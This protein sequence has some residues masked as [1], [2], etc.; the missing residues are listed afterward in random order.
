[1]ISDKTR[2][3]LISINQKKFL[4]VFLI[5]WGLLYFV[6]PKWYIPVSRESNFLILILHLLYFSF[7]SFYL[8]NLLK[9]LHISNNYKLA[10]FKNKLDFKKEY[11]YALILVGVVLIN[12]WFIFLVPANYYLS[13]ESYQR[14]LA[15]SLIIKADLILGKFGLIGSLSILRILIISGI[16]IT[17][18]LFKKKI[19]FNY[20]IDWFYSY[21]GILVFGFV[22]LISSTFVIV[23]MVPATIDL[24]VFPQ[25]GRM[26]YIVGY[27]ILGNTVW[28]GR[29]IQLI[30][31]ITSCYFIFLTMNLRFDRETSLLAAFI[32][33]LIPISFYFRQTGNYASG[34]LLLLILIVYWFLRYEINNQSEDL[35]VTFYLIGIGYNYKRVIVYML[36]V[37]WIYWGFK[38]IGSILK[39]QN[40]NIPL[41]IKFTWL[42]LI[43]IVPA[44]I[45]DRYFSERIVGFRISRLM[46]F[47]DLTLMFRAMPNEITISV[48]IF[49]VLGVFLCLIRKY[50]S[51]FPILMIWF[52]TYYIMFT[53]WYNLSNPRYLFY[54]IP[55]VVM[56]ASVSISKIINLPVFSYKIKSTFIYLFLLLLAYSSIPHGM[57]D[58]EVRRF[59]RD[60]SSEELEW[61]RGIVESA[62][63]RMKRMWKRDPTERPIYPIK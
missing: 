43:P 29:I 63:S 12:L 19:K 11:G 27:S 49:F 53:M 31:G 59:K 52:L 3:N 1:M 32:Y 37:F 23:T 42:A 20:F 36:L 14:F 35:L 62:F 30:F 47:N 2:D 22:I 40:L 8:H 15:T 13:D 57:P 50:N 6:W 25:L 21:R 41:K 55:P 24:Y 16:L 18:L 5:S 61:E 4:L 9:K 45:T 56:I 17:F 58:Q 7:N 26:I 54:F 33:L 39:K 48:L 28:T 60:Q 34:T 44:Y 10:I 38:S 46:D 51:I